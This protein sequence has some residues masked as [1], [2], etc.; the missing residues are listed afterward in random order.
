MQQWGA[1]LWRCATEGG[2]S[3]LD[4]THKAAAG[5]GIEEERH[6]F[7]ATLYADMAKNPALLAA[8]AAVASIFDGREEVE[9]D[10]ALRAIEGS[11]QQGDRAQELLTAL[12]RL[13][14]IWRHPN[15]EG[16]EPGIPGYMTYLLQRDARQVGG[17]HS[18]VDSAA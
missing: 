6:S 15:K 17:L 4:A 18:K 1:A 12:I 11:G 9:D 8:M 7:Y 2:L 16:Y 13:E 3:A 5:T 10:E 14:F